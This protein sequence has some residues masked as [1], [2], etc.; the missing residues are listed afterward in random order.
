MK[1]L[2]KCITESQTNTSDQDQAHVGQACIITLNHASKIPIVMTTAQ[3]FSLVPA[4]E[5]LFAFG[6]CLSF[7]FFKYLYTTL[8]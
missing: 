8:N 2:S 5:F 3:W 7:F 6:G 1:I 4:A